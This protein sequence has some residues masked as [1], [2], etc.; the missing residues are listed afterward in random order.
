MVSVVV[1]YILAVIGYALGIE[2]NM[3]SVCV[4]DY[5]TPYGCLEIIQFIGVSRS[6]PHTYHPYEKIVVPILN[7]CMCLFV[8]I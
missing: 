1:L 3:T 8:A 5:S 7:V 6:E 4:H 2:L